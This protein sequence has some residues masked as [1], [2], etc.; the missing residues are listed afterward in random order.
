MHDMALNNMQK[1]GLYVSTTVLSD[2]R[3]SFAERFSVVCQKA[4]TI[5]WLY[6]HFISDL[7]ENDN[8]YLTIL[9]IYISMT[10]K[11]LLCVVELG[12]CYNSVFYQD[13]IKL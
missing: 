3:T 13:E 6:I 8:E 5:F 4:L 10:A 9:Q 2:S 7:C 1:C 11:Y 12:F